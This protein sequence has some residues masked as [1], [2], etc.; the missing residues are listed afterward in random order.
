MAANDYYNT[1]FSPHGASS[2][3]QQHHH[4]PTHADSPLPPVPTNHSAQ[5]ISPVNSPFDDSHRYDY[6]STTNL[7]H[8]QSTSSSAYAD[9]A[10]HGAQSPHGYNSRYDPPA[11]HSDPFADQNAIPLQNQGKMGGGHATTGV[12]GADP[13]GRYPPEKRRK[14]KGWFSGRVTWVVYF[15]TTV[16]IAV[17]I[18]EII[19]NGTLKSCIF[20]PLV[21]A[22]ADGSV[23]QFA[24]HC[25]ADTDHTQ[26]S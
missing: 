19:K 20:R 8:A 18:G 23:L 25:A 16:Q 4:S 17:F 22:I 10:Y 3:Q 21:F 12:Y 26:A 24:L 5:S 6:P 14:K 13:E 2:Q 1:S 9:T 11:N 15:L 7:T